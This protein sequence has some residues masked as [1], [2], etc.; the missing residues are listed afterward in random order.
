[1]GYSSTIAIHVLV[2]KMKVILLIKENCLHQK[3]VQNNIFS[4][5]LIEDSQ[6]NELMTLLQRRSLNLIVEKAKQGDPRRESNN[7]GRREFYEKDYKGASITQALKNFM[8]FYLPKV[9]VTATPDKSID[10]IAAE[11]YSETLNLAG[12]YLREH[13][14]PNG[15]IPESWKA[16][17]DH[18]YH[19]MIFERVVFLHKRRVEVTLPI[20]GSEYDQVHN[21]L[22]PLHLMNGFWGSKKILNQALNNRRKAV[23]DKLKRMATVSYIQ[24]Y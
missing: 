22:I 3:T 16:V 21:H 5:I 17:C 14:I 8:V 12:Q 1:M 4:L 18:E 6:G 2:R 13:I 23:S 7:L 24:L 11:R 20:T 19:E 10:D 9:G 15:I